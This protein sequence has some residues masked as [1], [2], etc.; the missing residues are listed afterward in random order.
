MEE[1]IAFQRTATW[2]ESPDPP[3]EA[4]LTGIEH[5]R[6]HERDQRVA[7]DEF[8]PLATKPEGG[9]CWAPATRPSHRPG[10]T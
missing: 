10:S 6:E 9:S 8:G 2:K 1:Q 7:F 5:L 4:E 3:G